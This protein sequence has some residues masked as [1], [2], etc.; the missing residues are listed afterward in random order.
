[1]LACLK[2]TKFDPCHIDVILER[3]E[4]T[5]HD[6]IMIATTLMKICS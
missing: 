6:N 4:N 2:S 3:E 5:F 1:M